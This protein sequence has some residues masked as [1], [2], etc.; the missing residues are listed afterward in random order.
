[1]V[2]RLSGLHNPQRLS[3]NEVRNGLARGKA[4]SEEP[5]APL[6]TS[7]RSV[8]GAR[9]QGSQQQAGTVR[10]AV[11]GLRYHTSLSGIP[12]P[13][14]T[15]VSFYMAVRKYSSPPCQ[16]RSSRDMLGPEGAGWRAGFWQESPDFEGWRDLDDIP[17][18]FFFAPGGHGRGKPR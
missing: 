12:E 15:S 1:M 3:G 16:Q 4:L 10:T 6:Q 5:R 8:K 17:A 11:L 2:S 13:K 9:F 14:V 18:L 7:Q